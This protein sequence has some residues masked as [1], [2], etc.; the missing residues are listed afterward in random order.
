M[1]HVHVLPQQ[2]KH[3][4][5]H[6]LRVTWTRHW[7]LQHKGKHGFVILAHFPFRFL[8]L[9]L[10]CIGAEHCITGYR[11]SP[12]KS[13][14]CDSIRSPSRPSSN[15]I[16]EWC[17]WLIKNLTADVHTCGLYG[18]AW[19]LH[20]SSCRSVEMELC[21]GPAQCWAKPFRIGGLRSGY[22]PTT[23]QTKCVGNSVWRKMSDLHV[24]FLSARPE[25]FDIIVAKYDKWVKI[26]D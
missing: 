3:N 10:E 4:H 26:W 22:C 11:G 7:T 9:E 17:L 21:A 15:G 6:W 13:P 16:D 19:L 1:V 2:D 23:Q 25:K 12:T 20:K 24:L 5:R 18:N 14:F 8:C